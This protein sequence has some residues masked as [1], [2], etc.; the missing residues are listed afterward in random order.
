[1]MLTNVLAFVFP[2]RFGCAC[3]PNPPVVAAVL[4][5]AF[6]L[7]DPKPPPPKALPPLEED[8][9]PVPPPKPLPVL[10]AK[11]PPNAPELLPRELEPNPPVPLV[12][13]ELPNTP[14]VAE[15]FRIE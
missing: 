13:L 7:V 3:I 14:P 6:V 12:V 9:K 1:M 11:P 2:R 15:P 8:P 10:L 5:K 4:P